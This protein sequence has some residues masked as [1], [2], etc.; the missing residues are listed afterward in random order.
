MSLLTRFIFSSEGRNP[1][2]SLYFR[3]TYHRNSLSSMQRKFSGTIALFARFEARGLFFEVPTFHSRLI[4]GIFGSTFVVFGVTSHV[5]ASSLSYSFGFLRHRLIIR[6][7]DSGPLNYFLRASSTVLLFGLW[8]LVPRIISFR[9]A[10][11]SY[12]SSCGFWSLVLFPL[13]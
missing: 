10:A 12:C 1:F 3:G 8:I 11:P 13:G 2:G 9:P 7:G 6:V 4:F 5:T